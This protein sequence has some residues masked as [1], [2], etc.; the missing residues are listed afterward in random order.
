MHAASMENPAHAAHS[1][2]KEDA[3]ITV[4]EIR[5]CSTLH[6]LRLFVHCA[7]YGGF[8][9][10]QE[11]LN[12]ARGLQPERVRLDSEDAT[13]AINAVITHRSSWR[14]EDQGR[15]VAPY[16][17]ISR[18]HQTIRTLMPPQICDNDP[19]PALETAKDDEA[20]IIESQGSD[21]Q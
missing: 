17:W 18:R 16:P 21:L 7:L 2:A 8:N 15:T 14:Y 11:W 20:M 13:C 4:E 5:A 19:M 6:Y 3:V 1:S 10:D 9:S 12:V